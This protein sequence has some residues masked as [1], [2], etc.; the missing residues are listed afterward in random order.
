[1]KIME[2]AEKFSLGDLIR[3]RGRE[4]VVIEAG[5]TLGLRPLTGTEKDIEYILPEIEKSPVEH[6]IFEPPT[7]ERVGG[8]DA[9]LLLRDALRLSL[10]RG[11]GPFRGAGKINF[12]PRPYQLVPLL[13]ALRL[14]PVRLLN[15]DD[16]GIGKT[17]ETGLILREYVDRGEI[18][19]FTVLCPPHLIEQWTKELEE[20]FSFSITPVT[21]SAAIR[22]ERDLSDSMSVF[23]AY[24]FTVVSLDFIKSDKRFHDFVRACPNMVVV[25]EAHSA[26]SS[27]QRRQQRYDL[28]RALANDSERHLVLLTATPHSGNEQ[29]YY[30]LLGLIDEKFKQLLDASGELRQSLRKQL[31]RHFIQRRRVDI[32]AW[33][34]AG[35]FPTHETT[36]VAY[37]LTGDYE[38]FYDNVLDYCVE[39]VSNAE[40]EYRQRLAFWGTLALMRCVCSSPAAAVSA[41]KTRTN[42]EQKEISEEY[43]SA[44]VL[45]RED[46]VSDDI[47]PD[48]GTFNQ[49]LSNLVCQ[50]EALSKK[51]STDP[52][53]KA[54]VKVLKTLVSAGFNPVVFCR[55]IATASSVGRALEKE[56]TRY[57]VE[58]VTGILSS[59]ERESRVGELGNHENRILVATDCLSE[60]INLQALFDSVVHYDLCWNPT[61]HQQREGR[62]DR[63]GQPRETVRSAL[64]YGK[65]NAVDLVVL[66]V[67]LRKARKIQEE[68]GVRIPIP[69]EN[70]S[71]TRALMSAVIFRPHYSQQTTIDFDLLEPV[72]D[73]EIA[74]RNASELEKKSS[75][76]FAQNTLKPDEVNSEWNKSLAVFGGYRDTERFVVQAMKRLNAPLKQLP[77]PGGY[78]APIGQTPERIRNRLQSEGLVDEND[79]RARIMKVVFSEKPPAGATSIHRTHPLPSILADTILEQTLESDSNYSNDMATLPRLGAWES[80]GVDE[81]TWLAILR[82]RHKL[83]S[84]GKLGPQFNLAE[85]AS[86]IALSATTRSR[87]L[88]DEHAF[89]LLNA[90]SYDL[91]EMIRRQELERL[92]ENLP[93]IKPV[94]ETFSLERARQLANDHIRVRR[95]LG[96]K[97]KVRVEASIPVDV[98][99]IYALL[100]VL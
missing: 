72:K 50:A 40:G 46:M 31:S 41:L 20:K 26:V 79:S 85:E 37:K 32:D 43:V 62:V 27:G 21:A 89:R 59:E 24:P 55:Y 12:E 61:R 8:R 93:K 100:P 68:T 39:I 28:V 75:T 2:V 82:I 84:S 96:S 74:W 63:F 49:A 73:I 97:A 66:K 90:R 48:I 3:A 4:W 18:D 45:D 47:E 56:F 83:H 81:V 38:D 29:A 52:K 91:P 5:R 9:A 7:V 10:R 80:E 53:F 16:V 22:L 15:A 60:G 87:L 58:T 35:L 44:N 98:I 51:I 64:I 77:I 78:K 17:I 19:R 1:M 67:I 25:D 65:N 42:T 99:G 95:T 71:L 94:L 92:I 57:T 88:S 14:E 30:N 69:D 70:G 6:A 36:D 34:E 54:L 33:Q 23:D 13:M 76:R 11:A 86:A